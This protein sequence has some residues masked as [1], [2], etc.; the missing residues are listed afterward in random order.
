MAR[1]RQPPPP[2][3]RPSR[4]DWRPVEPAVGQKGGHQ[5]LVVLGDKAFVQQ[6]LSP[7][8]VGPD[9][10]DVKP[11]T[12]ARQCGR[13]GG[14]RRPAST[15]S[16]RA[17]SARIPAISRPTAPR[18]AE[19]KLD[20]RRPRNVALTELQPDVT[21]FIAAKTSEGVPTAAAIH[22]VEISGLTTRS[23]ALVSARI[24]SRS[25][26]KHVGWRHEGEPSR[27]PAVVRAATSSVWR[28]A[29]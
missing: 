2:A 14:G 12:A 26:R 25:S 28:I 19:E 29:G 4:R 15:T 20:I 21:I 1:R 10:I 24:S 18:R 27:S 7:L 9:F 13:R 17:T 16:W 5:G 6:H 22:G 23:S 8:G 3:R 11:R